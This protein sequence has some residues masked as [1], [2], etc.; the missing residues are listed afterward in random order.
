MQVDIIRTGIRKTMA[1]VASLALILALVPSSAL[2]VSD[3]A[4]D[5]QAQE[6]LVMSGTWGTCPWEITADGTL[7]IHPGAGDDTGGKPP[8]DGEYNLFT[9]VVFAQEGGSKV[10]APT[11]SGSLFVLASQIESIDL[12]GLDTS[13]VENMSGMFDS[14]R[15][16]TAIDLSGLDLSRVTDMGS[17]FTDC[18]SLGSLDFSNHDLSQLTSISKAFSDCSS[19]TSVDFSGA[20]L[21]Q[22]TSMSAAFTDCSSLVTIDLSGCNLSNVTDAGGAFAG[23][24]ALAS[25]DLTPLNGSQMTN[26]PGMFSGCSALT[27]LDLSGLDT[28]QVTGVHGMFDGCASLE[29]ISLG[30]TFSF[31]GTDNEVQATL[32]D[33]NWFSAR[34]RQAYSSQQIAESRNNMKDTYTKVPATPP[35]VIKGDNGV[36]MPG[37]ATGI[38]FTSD[39]DF[40]LFIGVQVDGIDLDESNYVASEGSTVITLKPEYAATLPAGEH[41]IGILSANGSTEATFV[42]TESLES[43][44]QVNLDQDAFVYDGTQKRP[45]IT[46]KVGDKVLK[47]GVDYTV[48]CPDS[49]IAAGA[50]VVTVTGKGNYSGTKTASYE[51]VPASIADV[52][53]DEVKYTYDGTQKRPSVTVKCAGGKVLVE[54]TDYTISYPAS[55]SAVGMYTV[56]V[57]GKGN[58]TGTKTATFDI[59]A[60]SKPDDSGTENPNPDDPGTQPDDPGTNDPQPDDPATTDPQPISAQTMYRLYNPNSGEHFYTASIEERD[61]L[62]SVGWDYEGEA[63]EAPV[64]S[65]TPVYRLYSGTDHHYTTSVHERDHLIDAGWKYEGIGWYSDDAKGVGLH[66]LFNP[67]VNPKAARNNSGSH[68]YTTSNEERDHLVSLGWRYEDYGWYGVR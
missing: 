37:S 39:A 24:S 12:S 3:D 10:I 30:A 31:K 21:S 41:R 8:W 42:I 61:H 7:T 5:M 33:G 22:L 43:A 63:W 50:Y 67:N 55:S 49:S 54:G 1:I 26:M 25:L 53:L 28:S 27:S 68:H 18:S 47:Q 64:S 66:R 62:D 45:M 44:A 60:A 57:T 15:A 16:L 34:E 14:C 36:W 35:A 51:I 13:K 17:V 2:A 46:V 11:D 48:S 20:D 40:A 58:Y 56:T 38:A 6:S 59:A 32:P 65:D 23:C 52:V 29:K 9:R 19:L 4:A